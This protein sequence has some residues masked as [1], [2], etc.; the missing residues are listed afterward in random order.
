[1]VQRKTKSEYNDNLKE[2]VKTQIEFLKKENY[3]K[4]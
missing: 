1:M 4:C 3:G 2:W